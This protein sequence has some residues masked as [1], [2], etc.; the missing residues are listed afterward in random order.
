MDYMKILYDIV[1]NQNLYR[2]L[3]EGNTVSPL[4]VGRRNGVPIHMFF[5]LVPFADRYEATYAIGLQSPGEEPVLAQTVQ[6]ISTTEEE[7]DSLPIEQYAALYP[8]VFELAAQPEWDAEAQ[9][10]VDQYKKLLHE[11]GLR[12]WCEVIHKQ[13][14]DVYWE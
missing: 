8:Q 6:G 12:N 5:V 4:F 2:Y 10:T 11:D 3:R 7:L 13:F 1:D 9:A 14:P